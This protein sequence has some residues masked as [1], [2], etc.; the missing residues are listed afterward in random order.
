MR[1][2]QRESTASSSQALRGLPSVQRDASDDGRL[3]SAGSRCPECGVLQIAGRWTWQAPEGVITRE[4][5]AQLCPACSSVRERRPTGTLELPAELV[6]DVDDVLALV[7]SVERA[8]REAHPMER[9]MS[10]ELSPDGLRVTTTGKHLVRRLAGSLGRR[11]HRRPQMRFGV[12]Q[13]PVEVRWL[14]R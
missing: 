1:Q 4:L 13:E 6:W 8:E 12:G 11:L 3:R 2:A 14:A 5:E 7:R 10:V 9:L